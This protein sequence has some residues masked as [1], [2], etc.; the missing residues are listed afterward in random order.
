MPSEKFGENTMANY[1][2]K[3]LTQKDKFFSRK[4][5]PEQLQNAL[6]SYSTEGWRVVTAATAEI[7]AGI[8][9]R[10]EIIFILERERV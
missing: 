6:N 2:Y 5:D 8:G 4:F 9:S 3:V 1:E 7:G 10:E